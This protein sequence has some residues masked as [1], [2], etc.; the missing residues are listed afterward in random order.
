[1]SKEKEIS[2]Y[3]YAI[4]IVFLLF[5]ASASLLGY[6]YYRYDVLSK[7]LKSV[8]SE[9]AQT[10]TEL[11]GSMREGERLSGELE[12]E[13][14]KNS[15]FGGQIQEITSTVGTLD[16]LS[17]TDKELLEKYSKVYFLNEHY[18]PNSLTNI[19]PDYIYEKGKEMKIHTQVFPFLQA[20]IVAAKNEKIDL[21]IIS[22]YRSF[23]EQGALK[24]GYTLS[25]GTGANSFSA[26]Q[27][28]SEHQLGTTVDFT[29][30]EIGAN[31]NKFKTTDGYKWL[32]DN[33]YKYGFILSYPE[34]NGYYQF[35]P[36]HWRFVGK[37]LA[38]MLHIE[39]LH[40]YDL[41]QNKIDAYLINIF[42]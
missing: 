20:M 10:K 23:G 14:Y 33:A 21:K 18:V 28:Y 16:K 7:N 37:K 8:S 2:K 30:S 40:F 9:L 4:I 5:V 32:Q 27:G 39:G 13:K 26:D 19:P 15:L 42:D 36:W 38:E 41:S 17:K 6:L 34:G 12:T 29:T 35:E 22:A 24:T 1:M 11:E 3:K 31:F 25:Y